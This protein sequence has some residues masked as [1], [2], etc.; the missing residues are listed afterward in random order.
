MDRHLGRTAANFE[1]IGAPAASAASPKPMQKV[2]Q[3]T[4]G[5]TG[6]QLKRRS[7]GR[8]REKGADDEATKGRQVRAPVHSHSGRR[9]LVPHGPS[10]PVAPPLFQAGSAGGA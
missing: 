5:Q 6:V 9:R 3:R 1:E 10:V 7:T 2:A 4:T 8:L